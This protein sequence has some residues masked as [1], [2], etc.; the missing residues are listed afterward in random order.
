MPEIILPSTFVSL[1]V[2]MPRSL[3]RWLIERA[4]DEGVSANQLAVAL[5]AKAL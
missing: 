4:Q 3:H 2:R 5:L 1:L